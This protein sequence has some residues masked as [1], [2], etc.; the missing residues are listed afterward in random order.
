MWTFQKTKIYIK[1]DKS[2]WVKVNKCE[3]AYRNKLITAHSTSLAE[4]IFSE[5]D[6]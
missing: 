3:F 2:M 5:K 1:K 6:T 4:T